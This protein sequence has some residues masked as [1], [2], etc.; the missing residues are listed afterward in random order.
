MF[1]YNLCVMMLGLWSTFGHAMEAAEWRRIEDQFPG[2]S[3]KLQ[4]QEIY[5]RPST[6]AQQGLPQGEKVP[7]WE[8]K[9]FD[10]LEAARNHF[11]SYKEGEPGV[12][13]F[14]VLHYTVV[15]FA[16]TL[17][18]FTD[19]KAPVPVATHYVISETEHD[20]DTGAPLMEGGHIFQLGPLEKY[21]YHVGRSHWG[22]RE[23]LNPLSIGIEHVNKGF[24][25]IKE[26]GPLEGENVRWY[27]FDPLQIEASVK[28]QQALQER[29][30]FDPC[31]IVTHARVG[32]NPLGRKQDPGPCW[33]AEYMFQHGLGAWLTAKEQAGDLSETYRDG[34]LVVPSAPYPQEPD[35]AYLLKGLVNLGMKVSP[36]IVDGQLDA[37]QKAAIQIW[38]GDFPYNDPTAA[39]CAHYNPQVTQKDMVWI[40]ALLHKYGRSHD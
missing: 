11:W 4:G 12:K 34:A 8:V 33:P 7:V 6:L 26:D 9:P 37:E 18:I 36:I 1:R 21:T 3:S 24:T 31:N 38:H 5:I 13:D 2:L 14:L 15:D 30:K 22:G 32:I 20:P 35:A 25:K 39:I 27:P 19:P 23:T 28:L 29:F 40:W 17:K 10:A 16:D